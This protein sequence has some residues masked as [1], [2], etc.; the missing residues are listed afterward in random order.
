MEWPDYARCGGHCQT[1]ES[2]RHRLH[3]RI[4][5]STTIR[6]N[7]P[8]REQQSTCRCEYIPGIHASG[9][10]ANHLLARESS[11][12][13]RNFSIYR[14]STSVWLCQH[15]Y[16]MTSTREKIRVLL[17]PLQRTR[18]RTPFWNIQAHTHPTRILYRN[19][20]K[21]AP[22]DAVRLIQSCSRSSRDLHYPESLDLLSSA[23]ALENEQAFDWD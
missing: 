4:F 5:Q 13:T 6:L 19:L 16:F 11:N 12:M 15:F 1:L 2:N 3:F 22:T 18:A 7:V 9:S 10:V 23:A 21:L 8:F 20:L 14:L 17:Q